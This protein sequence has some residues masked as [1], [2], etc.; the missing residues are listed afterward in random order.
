MTP[1]D[2]SKCHRKQLEIYAKLIWQL[3]DQLRDAKKILGRKGV[4]ALTPLPLTKVQWLIG[5]AE[6]PKRDTTLLPEIHAEVIGNKRASHW[7]RVAK[8][9]NLSPMSLRK[10]IR[11][12]ERGFVKSKPVHQACNY[13]KL[14][15]HIQ[16]EVG[17]LSGADK[18]RALEF[19]RQRLPVAPSSIERSE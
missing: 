15:D 1:K 9:E 11:I 7:L 4:M 12:A 14:L 3:A 8:K 19:I 10:R 18:E 6:V 16:R 13:P 17:R 5:I 2:F